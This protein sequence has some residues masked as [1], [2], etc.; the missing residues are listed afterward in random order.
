M[1]DGKIEA[2]DY[3]IRWDS[4]CVSVI[5]TNEKAEQAPGNIAPFARYLCSLHGEVPKA[6]GRAALIRRSHTLT[7]ELER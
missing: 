7:V 4:S 1:S 3:D 5:M 2:G 6:T